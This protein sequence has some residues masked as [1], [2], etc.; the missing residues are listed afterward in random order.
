[1]TSELCANCGKEIIVY[2]D[3]K[4]RLCIVCDENEI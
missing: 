3:F 4:K 1:M 2:G